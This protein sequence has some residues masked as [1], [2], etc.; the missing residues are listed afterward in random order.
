VPAQWQWLQEGKDLN[1]D[2]APDFSRVVRAESVVVYLD[3]R[4]DFRIVAGRGEVSKTG[5]P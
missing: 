3:V 1:G 4:F 5:P 2:G